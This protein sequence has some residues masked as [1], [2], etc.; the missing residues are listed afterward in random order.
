MF[1]LMVLLMGKTLMI[2]YFVLSI[3]Y[4]T[5]E[6][7]MAIFSY[8]FAYLFVGCAFWAPIT[9]YVYWF[10]KYKGRRSE[11][12]HILIY[13]LLSFVLWPLLLRVVYWNIDKSLQKN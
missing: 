4:L 10:M 9:C 1:H 6:F 3:P 8:F 7:W 13:L 11:K 12:K 2:D 5:S